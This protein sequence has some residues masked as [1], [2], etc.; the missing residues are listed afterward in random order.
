LNEPALFEV[1][2]VLPT[3]YDIMRKIFIHEVDMRRDEMK[4]SSDEEQ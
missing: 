3:Y 2:S 1:A 4:L